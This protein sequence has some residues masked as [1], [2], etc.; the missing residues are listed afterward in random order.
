[1][2]YLFIIFLFGCGV[3]AQNIDTTDIEFE[4]LMKSVAETNKKAIE[5]Q[6]KATKKEKQL[7]ANA[8][9]TITELKNDINELKS[10][11]SIV[12]IDT[13]YIHDTIQIKE[14]KNFWGKVKADTTN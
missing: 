8:V 7:V 13:I 11:I 12:K 5:V 3:Q 9:S 4:Q 14:K 2:K 6:V 10:V 1:M